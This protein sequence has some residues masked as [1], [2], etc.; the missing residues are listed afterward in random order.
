MD[1][2]ESCFDSAVGFFRGKEFVFVN[3]LAK[4]CI[5]NSEN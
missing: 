4:K 1:T 3:Q 2:L 5:N